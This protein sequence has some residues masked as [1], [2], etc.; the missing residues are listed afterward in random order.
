MAKFSWGPSGSQQTLNCVELILSG[1]LGGAS[2]IG[3]DTAILSASTTIQIR[4]P[5]NQ[6]DALNIGT[7]DNTYA[8]INDHPAI[9]TWIFWR[10]VLVFDDTKLSFGAAGPGDSYIEY[11]SA[12][13]RLVISGSSTAFSGSVSVTGAAAAG[14]APNYDGQ[15]GDGIV[16]MVEGAGANQFAGKPV[17]VC[18]VTGTQYSGDV[19]YVGIGTR[20]PKVPLDIRWN[21]D[22]N[23]ASGNVG[24]GDVVSFATGSTSA[25]ALYYLNNSGGWLSASA[26]ATGSGNNQLLGIALGTDAQND[27]ML[28]RGW[29][30]V[31]GWYSGS[32]LGGQAVYIH[33]GTAGFVS[34][35][36]PAADNSYSRIVGY[37]S[38]NPNTI[39]FNPGT[40]WIELTGS[41]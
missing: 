20:Q 17:L 41:S 40:T 5:A 11:V 23:A 24:G 26:H 16:F 7:Q 34:G 27:G 14:V 19:G 2:A 29:A 12:L 10:D 39:Y 1:C 8:S 25:G 4:A 28:I 6:V 37:A 13:D 36:A 21:V 9:N 33:S 15:G 32:F 38:P 22:L 35:A 31:S 3:G 30:D 18:Q